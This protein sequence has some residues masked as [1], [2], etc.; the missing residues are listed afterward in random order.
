MNQFEKILLKRERR[1]IDYKLVKLS[2]LAKRIKE[3]EVQKNIL[4]KIINF[5]PD[6]HIRAEYDYL[7]SHKEILQ[8]RIEEIN[9]KMIE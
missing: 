5:I 8:N 7:Y 9:Q 6:N 2:F 4:W 1:E 3:I